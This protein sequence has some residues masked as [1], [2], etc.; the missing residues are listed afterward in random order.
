MCTFCVKEKYFSAH[1]IWRH[2]QWQTGRKKCIYIL[3][4]WRGIAWGIW[5]WTISATVGSN[6]GA[7][8]RDWFSRNCSCF[9]VMQ[10]GLGIK[11]LLD[12]ELF[13]KRQL[14]TGTDSAWTCW[15][16]V[17]TCI[18]E[19]KDVHCILNGHQHNIYEKRKTSTGFAILHIK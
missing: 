17:M 5:R 8:H 12:D 7:D 2:L 13:R 11:W 3:D 10:I 6:E 9:V 1:K 4:W 14:E 19:M 18:F 15:N 16:F